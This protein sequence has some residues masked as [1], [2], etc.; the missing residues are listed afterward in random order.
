MAGVDVESVGLDVDKN[1][2]GTQPRDGRGGGK[3]RVAR[4]EDFVARP[5]VQGHQRQQERVAPR[6]AA[7]SVASAAISRQGLFEFLTVG[8]E[9]EP[10]RRANP[11]DGGLDLLLNDG[12][13]TAEIQKGHAAWRSLL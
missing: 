1:R 10:A 4:E 8:A 9:H 3:E 6:S 13:L 2:P 7:N 12:V 5:D 11:R